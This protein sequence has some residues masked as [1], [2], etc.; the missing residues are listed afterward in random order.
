MARASAGNSPAAPRR[1]PAHAAD[2]L[3]H[4]PVQGQSLLRNIQRISDRTAEIAAAYTRKLEKLQATFA[5]ARER[6]SRDAQA[7]VG[8]A[9][10]E[11][12]SA[13][14]KLSKHREAQQI[15]DLRR[16]LVASSQGERNQ[17]LNTMQGYANEAAFLASLC[18][19]PAIMLG[20]TA[21]GDPKRTQY[22]VQL[23]GAGPVELEAAAKQA[24]TT[25]DLVLAAAVATIID[26]RPSDRRPF[27]VAD[28]AT[29]IIGAEYEKVSRTLDGIQ[30]AMKSA[31]AAD[32]EFVRGRPIR[33]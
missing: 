22:Q 20:R 21:L 31:L 33:W 30:L 16:S 10:R 25:N 4:D 7:L 17:L 9:N 28:F 18:A 1:G 2:Q 19:S 26:R 32:R 3:Q 5:D 29:R 11:T 13:A 14:L 23:E 15:S 27:S 24:I 12:R 6:F 8:S